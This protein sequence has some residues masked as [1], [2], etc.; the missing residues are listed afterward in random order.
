MKVG[1]TGATGFIGSH[2]AAHCRKR[3]HEVVGYSRHPRPGAR[4]FRPDSSPD[5]TGL[6]GL[7]NLAGESLLGLW[8][9]KKK[10]LIRDSRI[11]GTRQIIAAIE[12]MT[13]RPRVLVNASA[14]GFYGD[15]GESLVDETSPAGSGFL[16]EVCQE[17]ENEA[18]RAEIFGL[19]VV[20]VR[21]GFVIGKGGALKIIGP[22]FKLG[23]G[24]KLGNGRQWMSGIHVEDVAEM[25]L[26]ALETEPL[27]GPIN[28]VMPAP[29]RNLDFTREL[30]RCVHRPAILPAPA[31]ALRLA[32]GELSHV[33]LDSSRVRPRV[34]S[35][36][37]YRYQF[38][39]LD[40]ALPSAVL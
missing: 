40:S 32:L 13:T 21:I 10:R 24:G 3:G 26:W 38:P 18:K 2:V 22:L 8:T 23:L 5:L 16:A 25:M 28:A 33:M 4:L 39:T 19:R 6:D 14:I 7:V 35:E 1:I 11:A 17:W 15:T 29:F 36:E 27:S 31:L 20:L 34:A 37:K 12:K 9:S 30:A